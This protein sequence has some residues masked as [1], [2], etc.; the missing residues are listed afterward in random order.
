M[1]L[2]KFQRDHARPFDEAAGAQPH[3]VVVALMPE[4]PSEE[5]LRD[6][7][8][9]GSLPRR[10]RPPPCWRRRPFWRTKAA[11]GSP[12]SRRTLTYCSPMKRRPT[13]WRRCCGT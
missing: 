11:R 5:D 6:N 3:P 12:A 8:T 2:R 1:L 10:S 4:D 9:P 13:M 7:W